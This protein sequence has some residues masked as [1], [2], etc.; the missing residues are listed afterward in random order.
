MKIWRYPLSAALL[1]NCYWSSLNHRLSL[2]NIAPQN[3]L[4]VLVHYISFFEHHCAQ[5]TDSSFNHLS[6]PSSWSEYYLFSFSG[7]TVLPLGGQLFKEC[8]EMLMSFSSRILPIWSIFFLF[9]NLSCSGI[10]SH[11]TKIMSIQSL[12]VEIKSEML[13]F[14]RYFHKSSFFG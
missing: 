3:D 2:N 1:I 8:R 4:N 11:I 12:V 6:L 10:K 14:L 13:V 5:L 7:S 9:G